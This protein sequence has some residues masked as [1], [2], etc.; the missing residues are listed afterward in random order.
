LLSKLQLKI[1]I[2]VKDTLLQP[3]VCLE[4]PSNN[5]AT[6]PSYNIIRSLH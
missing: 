6:E 2:R 4:L 1:V 5:N 3:L